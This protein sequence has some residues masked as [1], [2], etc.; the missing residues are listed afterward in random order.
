MS[1]N[2]KFSDNTNS[3]L[4]NPTKTV[5]D[6]GNLVVK[7]IS[8]S[9]NGCADSLSKTVN[10][11]KAPK[12]FFLTYDTALCITNNNFEFWNQSEEY[13]QTNQYTWHFGVGNNVISNN[14]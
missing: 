13:G 5:T 10:V 4:L 14:L 7:L 12:A 2:W 11:R 3:N 6:T 8:T 9:N 1:H